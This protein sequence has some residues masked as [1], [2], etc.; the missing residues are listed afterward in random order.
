MGAAK[1][2]KPVFYDG[3]YWLDL[4]FTNELVPPGGEYHSPESNNVGLVQISGDLAMFQIVQACVHEL[5]HH[6][7]WTR[8][9]KQTFVSHRALD[10][11]ATQ[12][13]VIVQNSPKFVEYLYEF[14]KK[15]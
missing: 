13:T 12:F 9:E 11:F 5:S 14:S 7:A 2:H 8:P 4:E 6:I 10:Y 1:K 3:Q 15:A